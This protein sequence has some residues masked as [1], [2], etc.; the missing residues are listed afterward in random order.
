MYGFNSLGSINALVSTGL[1]YRHRALFS[2]LPT[3][4]DLPRL[5]VGGYLP[6][7]SAKS[8]HAVTFKYGKVLHCSLVWLVALSHSFWLLVC[9]GDGETLGFQ[10][11]DV[12]LCTGGE[13][14]IV[15]VSCHEK[16]NAFKVR[17][18]LLV[19]DDSIYHLVTQ[20]RSREVAACQIQVL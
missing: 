5:T 4:S 19:G 20:S 18:L 2:L 14:T 11:S 7:M 17:V 10:G 12:L 8:S 16:I 13:V 1:A 6:G 9:L 15:P 3:K